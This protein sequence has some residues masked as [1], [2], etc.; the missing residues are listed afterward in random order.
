MP[1]GLNESTIRFISKKK[2]EPPF[3]L[4]F[5][6]SA[7]KHWLT[8]TPPDWAKLK[9]KPIDYQAISYY[10]APKAAS[11]RPK[12]LDDVDPKLLETYEKLGISLKEQEWLAGV[13]VDAVFDSVS[14]GTTFKEELAKQGIIFCSISEAVQTHPILIEKIFRFGCFLSR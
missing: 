5:R 11:D 10:A 13:A 8:L 4:A 6:L 9:L 7:Y 12:S 2:K 14:V 1:P 3:L